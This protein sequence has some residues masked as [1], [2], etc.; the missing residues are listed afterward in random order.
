[1]AEV[2]TVKVTDNK[3]Q[4]PYERENRGRI[5]KRA[6][7]ERHC[8]KNPNDVKAHSALG[9]LASS[10]TSS[11]HGYKGPKRGFGNP[12]SERLVNQLRKQVKNINKPGFQVPQFI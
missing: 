2:K 3:K 10:G 6:K 8:N 7:L 4:K 1:M 9:S 5:N 11:R 12:P